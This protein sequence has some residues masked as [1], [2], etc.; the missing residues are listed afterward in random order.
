MNKKASAKEAYCPT[1]VEHIA[2]ILTHGI[3]ILPSILA[4]WE[5][6]KRSESNAQYLSAFVYGATLVFLFTVSTSFHCVFYHNK[7]K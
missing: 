4:T 3:W 1:P 2:N 7:H 5:L 6:I